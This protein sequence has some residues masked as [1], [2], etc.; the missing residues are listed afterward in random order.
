M[1]RRLPVYLVLDCSE[2]MVGDPFQAMNNGLNLLVSELRSNPL[3]LETAAISI[4][5]F[6]SK[7]RQVLP[8]T[9]LLAAQIPSLKMGSGTALGQA[10]TLLRDCMSREVIK[11]S[12]TQKGDYKPV[13]FIITD[14]E[15]TDEWQAIAREYFTTI[16]GKKA[17]LIG[18]ACGRDSSPDVLRKLTETVITI[19]HET[20]GSFK[21][22]FQ[23][24]SATIST[25][26][27]KIQ[28]D[29]MPVEAPPLP[30]EIQGR[31]ESTGEARHVFLHVKCVKNKRF[32]LARFSRQGEGRG[33]AFAGSGV[34]PL[35][36]FDMEEGAGKK[37]R[38]DQLGNFN[39][40]P[41]CGN[42]ILG[43]CQCGNMHCCPTI[44]RPVQLT[45]PWCG[46]SDTYAPASFDLGSGAG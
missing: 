28:G 34:C 43:M 33:V 39:P 35:Q 42:Q 8:L 12:A 6:A 25:T 38:S 1:N 46:R 37:I 7:A 32:Y 9:D 18:V 17:N 5:T 29:G 30:A 21:K 11:S 26:S 36:N 20:P 10:L 40:C 4:I 19:D 13:V 23:W 22:F 14:G 2:S 27:Q 41:H 24:V 16:Q 44:T 15:P 45:C 3:A 31:T